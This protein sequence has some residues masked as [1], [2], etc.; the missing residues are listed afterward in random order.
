M[1]RSAT[2]A[3]RAASRHA[4]RRAMSKKTAGDVTVH[5]HGATGRLGSLICK[6]PGTQAL[7][8][9]ATGPLP[10]SDIQV[11]VDTSLPAGLESLL[12]RLQDGAQAG[13]SALPTVVVGT[14][15]KLPL[16]AIQ[17]YA[18]KAPVY[19]CP[20]FSTGIR[21]L[22]PTLKTL[23]ANSRYTAAV[24]EIHHTKK[25]D[26][27]S[28]TAVI[29]ANALRTEQVSSIRAADVKGIHRMD[30]IGEL[31]SIEITHTAHDRY[32]SMRVRAASFFCSHSI[33]V[34]LPRFSSLPRCR[35]A[36]L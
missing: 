2:A 5:V 22:L 9:R 12:S 19:I 31:E 18:Q 8:H 23:G 13:P 10:V 33:S 1:L 16:E 7:E 25:L 26:A 4:L 28:G 34:P 29:L 35:R 11:V 24:T 20:N 15:G 6:L 32:A 14:T 21:L 17:K 30:I 3:T 27:P 36:C